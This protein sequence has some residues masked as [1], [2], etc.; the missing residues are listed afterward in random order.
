MSEEIKK[1]SEEWFKEQNK[2]IRILD[3]DGWDR[4]NYQFSFYEELI[5]KDEFQERLFRS[6]CEIIGTNHILV[7]EW[8]SEGSQKLILAG[9]KEETYECAREHFGEEFILSGTEKSM[10]KNDYNN[11]PEW[12]G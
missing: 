8:E 6:T 4:S 2:V 5:T 12:Q 3:P 11:L 1:T 10:N 7:T 9:N